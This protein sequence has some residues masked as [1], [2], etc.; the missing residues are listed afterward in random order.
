MDS[1]PKVEKV[2]NP[3]RNPVINNNLI[4][5]Y[6]G[7]AFKNAQQHPIRKHPSKLTNKV[8]I[9]NPFIVKPSHL[10]QIKRA[11][12]PKAPPIPTKT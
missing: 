5:E 12:E 11:I 2:V 9:G 1:Y 7:S 10:E 3:P 6:L 4:D 8:P